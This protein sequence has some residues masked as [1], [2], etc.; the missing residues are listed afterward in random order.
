MH[1]ALN[2]KVRLIRNNQATA[3]DPPNRHF[4]DG[5]FLTRDIP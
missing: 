4:P 2:N 1:A 5:C 3:K